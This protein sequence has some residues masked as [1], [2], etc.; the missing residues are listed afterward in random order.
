MILSNYSVVL[1]CPHCDR[2]KSLYAL[3]SGNT[4]NGEIWSDSRKYYPMLPKPHPIQKCIHCGHYFFFN[5]GHPALVPDLN[6]LFDPPFPDLF[7]NPEDFGKPLR[8]E[9]ITPPLPSHQNKDTQPQ[10]KQLDYLSYQ[11]LDEAWK[12]IMIEGISE[13]RKKTYLL[14]F[15]FALNDAKY[16]RAGIPKQEIFQYYQ[17]RFRYFALAAI[18]LFGEEM[19]LTAELWRELGDFD[20]SIDLCNKLIDTGTDIKVVKQILARAKANDPNIFIL[21]NDN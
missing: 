21:D 7:G 12:D 2:T 1:R 11:E 5:D 14:R 6:K 16:G 10:K 9:K 19:T 18:D 13:G 20:K 17:E 8:D 15:I 3:A 4:I